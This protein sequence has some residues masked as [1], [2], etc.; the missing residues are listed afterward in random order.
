MMIAVGRI[1]KNSTI[2]TVTVA[3]TDVG[4]GR[5]SFVNLVWRAERSVACAPLL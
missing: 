2:P 4:R 5:Q 1:R 3:T